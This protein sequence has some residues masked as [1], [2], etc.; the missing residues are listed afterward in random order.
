MSSAHAADT[1]YLV[2]QAMNTGY[3]W[4]SLIVPPA[5]LVYIVARKGRGSLSLDR[6]LA[7]TWIG[8]LGGAAAF[9]GAA[10]VRNAYSSEQFVRAR[11][12]ET[13]YDVDKLRRNDHSTIGGVLAAVITPA[14]LWNRANV[15]NLI[16]GGAGLGSTAGIL[17]HYGRTM[18]GDPPAVVEVLPVP[19]S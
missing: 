19:T 12:I 1:D 17:T 4:S 18:S 8:G 6:F 13:A 15:V 3:Q 11:R 16:L 14:I 5:Y 2:R 7:A 10:Y 9:G